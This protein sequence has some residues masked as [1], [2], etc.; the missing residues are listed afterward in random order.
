M[1]NNNKAADHELPT[2]NEDLEFEKFLSELQD[3]EFEEMLSEENS[4]ITGETF[5][6]N[7]IY[8]SVDLGHAKKDTCKIDRNVTAL[9]FPT[10]FNPRKPVDILIYLHGF[11]GLYPGRCSTAKEYL[12][13][14]KKGNTQLNLREEIQASGKNVILVVPTLGPKSETGTLTNPGMFD[15]YM[16]NI[17][18][19]IE[20]Q[21]LK[22]R[23]HI[24]KM[25]RGKLI[26]SGHSG[27]GKPMLKIGRNA[28]LDEIWGFDCIYQGGSEW[29][30]IARAN[31][32]L[33]LFL[34]YNSDGNIYKTSTF[35]AIK[36]EKARAE[37]KQRNDLGNL[38][39]I[40]TVKDKT[41]NGHFKMIRP[42]MQQRLQNLKESAGN[43]EWEEE[44]EDG[45]EH[46]YEPKSERQNVLDELMDEFED[47][48]PAPVQF[49]NVP[50]A[51][52]PPEGSYWPLISKNESMH[53]ISYN[54]SSGLIGAKLRYFGAGRIS[55][56]GRYHA[57][58]DLYADLGD[59]IV[60]IDHGVIINHYPFCC[61]KNKTTYSL[62]VRHSNV[63]VNYGEVAKE[64]A[65]GLRKKSIVVPGQII[66]Y[67]GKNPHGSSMLHFEMYS[68]DTTANIKWFVGK[69][70]PSKLYDP[71]TY[72]L[73]LKNYGKIAD[74]GKQVSQPSS[75][76]VAP[77]IPIVPT[78]NTKINT[79]L[80]ISKNRSFSVKLG[81][82]KYT[83]EIEY[84]IGIYFPVNEAYFSQAVAKWQ[85]SQGYSDKDADGAIGPQ[86]WKL[87]QNKLNLFVPSPNKD[88]AVMQEPEILES[89][90]LKKKKN[91][92]VVYGGGKTKT[93]LCELK[94]KGLLRISSNE[95]AML[96][97]VSQNESGGYTSA[98]NNWDSAFMS[99]GFTQFTARYNT[100]QNIIRNAPAAF[101]KYGIELENPEQKYPGTNTIKIKGTNGRNDLRS[102]E[103][104]IKF[105]NAGLDN[106]IIIMQVEGA[107]LRFANLL[108]KCDPNH[109]LEQINYKA[110]PNLWAHIYESNNALPAPFT[111]AMKIAL[112]QAEKNRVKNPAEL[113]DI[114]V[115]EFEKAI[116]NYFTGKKNRAEVEQQ[117]ARAQS[118]RRKMY[119]VLSSNPDEA[120][121]CD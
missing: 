109:Y 34:Y 103:W 75:Y 107:R 65:P 61:G 113:S 91:G 50:F 10:H 62:L 88:S 100:L 94:R 31:P 112:A 8:T 114:I 97:L 92:W 121:Y 102:Q 6:N 106:D 70:A 4:V 3:G 74:G 58:I 108:S 33:K 98:I 37:K 95:I 35:R 90:T 55:S 119:K 14:N 39:V 42:A 47:A 80:A 40:E 104:A 101:Q 110:Y 99:L 67:V 89:M 19:A 69:P 27:G 82:A 66:G 13:F 49:K 38:M 24:N 83:K 87:M 41:M 45:Y 48:N 44:Y 53:V 43:I 5:P 111:T 23:F 93:K 78:N 57:G 2:S 46:E 115:V 116:R 56:G 52:L 68:A 73:H 59:P 20:E 15:T 12:N 32:N 85:K 76:P 29:P 11:L 63:V 81:W 86:T 22:T 118:I 1:H 105:Y 30:T 36:N 71:T 28:R 64:L 25:K 84:L 54:A 77:T 17:L 7:T 51:P 120:S 26:L 16:K 72:L 18:S 21:I 96:S 117:V 9:F 60:A 79:D